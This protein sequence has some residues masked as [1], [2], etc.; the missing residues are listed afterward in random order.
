MDHYSSQV[1]AHFGLIDQVR[2]EV[3]RDLLIEAIDQP[4]AAV[5]AVLRNHWCEA[6]GETCD[7]WCNRLG[8]EASDLDQQIGRQWRWLQWCRQTF[9]TGVESHYLKRK[10]G[11]DQVCFW[12]LAVNDADLAE[13]LS[14]RLREGETSMLQL[15]ATR[16]GPISLNGV[17]AELRPILQAMPAGAVS[18]PLPHASGWQLVQVEQ[19]FPASL[20]ASLRE[21]LLLELGE[22]ALQRVLK[23]GPQ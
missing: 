18:A 17:E 9:S 21:R 5:L 7:Q 13:E 8:L 14:L 11:L 20:D 3:A 22:E 6:R 4:A 12:Q 16:R 10:A 15:R 23:K 19:H 1:L 2:A